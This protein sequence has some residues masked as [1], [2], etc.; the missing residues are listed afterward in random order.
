ML[1][2]L[3]DTSPDHRE[4]FEVWQVHSPAALQQLLLTNRGRKWTIIWFLT[5]N[6]TGLDGDDYCWINQLK[7]SEAL[8]LLFAQC[9]LEALWCDLP[10][11][12]SVDVV[13]AVTLPLA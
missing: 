7:T 12:S 5:A 11:L 9:T 1:L 3:C 13:D 10:D 2:L 8:T 4:L 6:T